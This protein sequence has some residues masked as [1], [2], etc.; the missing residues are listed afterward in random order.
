MDGRG[1]GAANF[2]KAKVFQSRAFIQGS[3]AQPAT[4]A[5]PDDSCQG[6]L[7]EWSK[8]NPKL[9]RGLVYSKGDKATPKQTALKKNDPETDRLY[10]HLI[11]SINGK[12][13][14]FQHR[15]LSLRKK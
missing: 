9:L 1:A 15:K 11:Q 8:T 10:S 2:I 5:A 7:T 3:F 14:F 6:R 12:L 4:C 13:F